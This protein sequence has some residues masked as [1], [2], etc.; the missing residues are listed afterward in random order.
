MKELMRSHPDWPKTLE[1]PEQREARIA[2]RRA[3]DP[4]RSLVGVAVSRARV[5]YEAKSARRR[6]LHAQIRALETNEERERRLLRNRIGIWARS[7]AMSEEEREEYKKGIS[8]SQKRRKA[9]REAGMRPEERTRLRAEARTAHYEAIAE[10]S[11]PKTM[12]PEKRKEMDA[13]TLERRA[14]IEKLKALDRERVASTGRR[15]RKRKDNVTGAHPREKA[16]LYEARY[17]EKQKQ[18]RAA[19]QAAGSTDE[20]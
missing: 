20:R 7:L 19:A 9:E 6:E 18:K 16:R 15:G 10:A 14:E 17:R 2:R 13:K 11:R 1:T 8:E 3:L 5:D 12:T 4:R